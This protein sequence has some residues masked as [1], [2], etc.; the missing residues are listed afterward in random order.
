MTPEIR[1]IIGAGLALAAQN[2]LNISRL[3]RGIDKP[4]E[5]FDNK[6]TG[7]DQ[8]LSR[9]EGRLDEPLRVAVIET[10]EAA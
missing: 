1:A 5:K 7:I 2:Q 3:D 6:I 10:E 8:R 9:I 4:D